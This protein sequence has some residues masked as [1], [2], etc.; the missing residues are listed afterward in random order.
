MDFPLGSARH[1]SDGRMAQSGL[2]LGSVIHGVSLSSDAKY[3]ATC[4]AVF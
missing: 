1:T 4:V 3:V 2:V